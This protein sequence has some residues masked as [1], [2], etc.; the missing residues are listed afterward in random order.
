VSSVP[1]EIPAVCVSRSR[2]VIARLAGTVATPP[3]FFTATVVLA[4][5]G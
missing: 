1:Y 2:M 3:S 5:L 4:K